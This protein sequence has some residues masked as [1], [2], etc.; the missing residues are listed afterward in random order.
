MEYYWLIV[1]FVFLVFEGITMNLVTVWFAFGALC[2][3]ISAYFTDNIIIELMIFIISTT[4][5]LILTRPFVKNL[6][7][8]SEKTNVDMLIGKTAIALTD[9]MPLK[10]GRVKISGKNW[11]AASNDEI[12][13]DEEV[14]VLKIEGA[15]LIV[16]KKEK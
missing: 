14:K 7:K 10:N 3:F 16:K 11:M 6:K 13:K 1:I 5:S 15:K 2:A 12:K 4:V 8:N 9:I